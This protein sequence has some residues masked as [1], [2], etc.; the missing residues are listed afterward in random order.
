MEKKDI[1]VLVIVGIVSAIASY[2]LAGALITSSRDKVQTV[3]VIEPILVDFGLP[4]DTYFNGESINPAQ[5]IT[6]T[7]ESNPNPFN[8]Q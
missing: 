8:G 4:N 6:L 1:Q 3:E 2:F 5:P 7:P